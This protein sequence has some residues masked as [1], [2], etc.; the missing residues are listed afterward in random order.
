MGS[1]AVWLFGLGVIVVVSMRPRRR[2]AA[3]RPAFIATA[4]LTGTLGLA[5]P[6]V[7]HQVDR[8]A[9]SSNIA[10]LVLHLA[11]NTAVYFVGLALSHTVG[12]ARA[13]RGIRG[14]LGRCVFGGVQAA[15]VVAFA[16]IDMSASSV[17][18]AS[19]VLQFSVGVYA[20]LGRTYFAYVGLLLVVP[21]ARMAL[22]KKVH[23]QGRVFAACMSTAFALGVSTLLIQASVL[24]PGVH[25]YSL[26]LDVPTWTGV[27][28]FLVGSLVAHVDKLMRQHR[29][30][31]R[32]GAGDKYADC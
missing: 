25:L 9:G 20:T 14:P 4:L 32:I 5:A 6:E 17:G 21:L 24:I 23:T 1:T 3:T 18:L 12:S 31:E 29:L 22:N 28:M 27:A 10:N 2:G 15:T 19:N 13:L 7:Y 26:E 8:L 30:E 11:L 16:L